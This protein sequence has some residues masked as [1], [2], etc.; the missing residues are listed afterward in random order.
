G[1]RIVAEND[2][3]DCLPYIF[4]PATITEIGN[5]FYYICME[6][7]PPFS[8]KIL[9]TESDGTT[10]NLS[11]EIANLDMISFDRDESPLGVKMHGIGD[12]LLLYSQNDNALFAIDTKN[13]SVA[14]LKK[15]L[16]TF[17]NLFLINNKMYTTAKTE[18][19]ELIFFVT[20]GTV[21]GTKETI[22]SL[23]SGNVNNISVAGEENRFYLI[24]KETSFWLFD[25]ENNTQKLITDKNDHVGL[26]FTSHHFANEILYYVDE[27]LDTL[28]VTDG[29]AEGT[30]SFST[31]SDIK[32]DT[33]FT[34]HN[35]L[36]FATKD[37]VNSYDYTTD[38]FEKIS[39]SWKEVLYANAID[40][41]MI[42][43]ARK[44]DGR[45]VLLEQKDGEKLQEKQTLLSVENN[46]EEFDELKFTVS[47]HDANDRNLLFKLVKE[48]MSGK[49]PGEQKTVLHERY[50]FISD[51]TASGTLEINEDQSESI[52]MSIIYPVT[53]MMDTYV[54]YPHFDE[55]TGTELWNYNLSNHTS[56]LLK[57]ISDKGTDA[58]QIDTVFAVGNS[59]YFSQQR[60]INGA[61]VDR[62]DL[63]C[64]EDG[65]SLKKTSFSDI[66]VKRVSFIDQSIA[67]E[68]RGYFAQGENIYAVDGLASTTLTFDFSD[69]DSPDR[70]F[71]APEL[72]ILDDRL[73]VSVASIV[74]D[75]VGDYFY[76]ENEIGELEE[77]TLYQDYEG[78][79]IILAFSD[80][81]MF[82][83]RSGEL[84]ALKGEKIQKDL[85]QGARLTL[86]QIPGQER[87]PGYLA[88]FREIENR[89]LFFTNEDDQT[90]HTLWTT[91]GT[92]EGTKPL[93]SFNGA[94]V[95][96]FIAQKDEVVYFTTHLTHEIWKTDGTKEGTQQIIVKE[97]LIAEGVFGENFFYFSL[98]KGEH[99]SSYDENCKS[100]EVWKS[101]GTELG[102]VK[103]ADFPFVPADSSFDYI[104][105]SIEKL[106][107]H[108]G[109]LFFSLVENKTRKL[110]VSDG[111]P[112]HTMKLNTLAA[113][114]PH[115][116]ENLTAAESY[117]VFTGDDDIHGS[118]L[119]KLTVTYK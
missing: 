47:R 22:P 42:V 100:G 38:V 16:T 66:P 15:R 54:V 112:E 57:D 53:I 48:Y 7:F 55:F 108:N 29:T 43:I 8:Y 117:M 107:F 103:I 111:T 79:I 96:N 86:L 44:E 118:E 105:R 94:G 2:W 61:G 97:G 106:H 60:K 98:N 14:V 80:E 1:T 71:Y 35:K 4:T 50:L 5:A 70:E 89:H 92:Q 33:L 76:K 115:D 40:N 81:T 13:K 85:T 87:A 102:T 88:S 39:A 99:C 9:Y 6:G 45:I 27:E 63:Y 56:E 37:A 11:D 19:G 72:S 24:I 84:W 30:K 68:K 104:D 69:R 36:F 78:K 110:Y 46:F 62:G 21:E 75:G 10:G 119:W 18:S 51:G 12:K 82:F 95:I 32:K 93:K 58:S 49:T 74:N 73:Y 90:Q 65:K 20:D 83:W 116:I 41:N 52:D 109:L 3:G 91:D 101:D 64:F 26:D 113:N 25:I 34:I 59:I 28:Y 114:L 77:M 31:D 23:E 67:A 17:E